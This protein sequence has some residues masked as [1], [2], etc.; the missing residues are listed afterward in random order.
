MPLGKY[1]SM[2]HNPVVVD[3]LI[4]TEVTIEK[5][6]MCEP[7]FVSESVD[8]AGAITL[9]METSETNSISSS[10]T[11]DTCCFRK[12]WSQESA[13][14]R[15]QQTR[16]M[17]RPGAPPRLDL[18]DVDVST[19]GSIDGRP[20]GIK[21][22]VQGK[23]DHLTLE[24]G[25][26]G[27]MVLPTTPQCVE[28]LI[29]RNRKGKQCFFP[30]SVHS[31]KT[32]KAKN[33]LSFMGNKEENEFPKHS[34]PNSDTCTEWLA[35]QR[36]YE[37]GDRVDIVGGEHRGK[38][39]YIV[40]SL[41]DRVHVFVDFQNET[42]SLPVES[43]QPHV[44]IPG[45]RLC[46]QNRAG[47][48][49]TQSPKA[50]SSIISTLQQSFRRDPPLPSI[51]SYSMYS[52][53][54]SDD[55]SSSFSDDDYLFTSLSTPSIIYNISSDHNF[56]EGKVVQVI[57]GPQRQRVGKIL[58]VTTEVIQVIIDGSMQPCYFS[59]RMLRDLGKR[60]LC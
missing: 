49:P 15:M 29:D 4:G 32:T 7:L 42:W 9:K 37:S 35:Q 56:R 25:G 53:S 51:E 11:S 59:P 45:S 43:V 60:A 10:N 2:I 40:H 41:G 52:S 17:N 28:V 39:G 21:R 55:E 26:V 5:A 22:T 54:F 33:F 50:S 24:I 18:I 31:S 48:P 3:L 27:E 34:E 16:S 6:G 44:F 58:R 30:P 57:E 12:D 23:N 46:T 38:T 36:A 8:S 19:G 14:G 1:S 20:G 47:P 13:I